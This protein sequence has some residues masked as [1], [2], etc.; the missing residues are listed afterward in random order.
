M[1][2]SGTFKDRYDGLIRIIEK[3]LMDHI[4]EKSDFKDISLVK[5][6]ASELNE[7]PDFIQLT[8]PLYLDSILEERYT[9][10]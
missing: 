9:M 4:A 10:F 5:S 7:N 2:N 1:S 3:N 8:K 6:V